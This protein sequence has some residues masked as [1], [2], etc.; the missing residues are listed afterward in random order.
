MRNI[1]AN[2]KFLYTCLSYFGLKVIK[3]CQQNVGNKIEIKM[4]GDH[5]TFKLSRVTFKMV[6]S[7]KIHVVNHGKHK[8]IITAWKMSK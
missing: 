1:Y 4:A 5:M 7:N 3:Y 8:N 6:K 2:L